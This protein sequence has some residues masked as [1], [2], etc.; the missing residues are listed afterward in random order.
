M[1]LWRRTAWDTVLRFTLPSI[2]GDPTLQIGQ[3]PVRQCLGV[4]SIMAR[5]PGY[6]E[7]AERLQCTYV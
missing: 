5:S 1:V 2:T 7:I 6:V 4:T 3:P